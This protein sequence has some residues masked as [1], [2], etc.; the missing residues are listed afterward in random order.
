MDF[1]VAACMLAFLWILILFAQHRMVAFGNQRK[2]AGDP[3]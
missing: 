3:L 1:M 2:L